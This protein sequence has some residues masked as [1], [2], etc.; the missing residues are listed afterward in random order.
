MKKVSYN[1]VRC[2]RFIEGLFRIATLFHRKVSVA[3]LYHHPTAKRPF[4][5]SSFFMPRFSF[6]IDVAR[7]CKVSCGLNNFTLRPPCTLC[8]RGKV[9]NCL[10]GE[11]EPSC[12]QTDV[13]WSRVVAS[14]CD[15][16][17]WNFKHGFFHRYYAYLIDEA[18][19]QYHSLSVITV[20]CV[21][22]FRNLPFLVTFSHWTIKHPFYGPWSRILKAYKA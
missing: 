5:V 1:S 2:W 8:C 20:A 3:R 12:V 22:S 15:T 16:S 17:V 13:T 9:P 11:G 7:R 4:S 18:F 6:L 21:I 14:L 19:C 10:V